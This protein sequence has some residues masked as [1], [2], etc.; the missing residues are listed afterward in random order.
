[1][2]SNLVLPLKR[3]F[4]DEFVVQI[5][6]FITCYFFPYVKPLLKDAY[7]DA[8]SCQISN[9][10]AYSFYLKYLLLRKTLYCSTSFLHL[11]IYDNLLIANFE[12][13]MNQESL[14]I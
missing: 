10:I 4:A 7:S 1:M 2:I 12:N 3:I 13:L 9:F 8:K 14:I 5:N 11:F 6:L